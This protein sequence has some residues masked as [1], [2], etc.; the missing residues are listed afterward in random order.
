ML[1]IP[2]SWQA[3]A[4]KDA[5]VFETAKADNGENDV[6]ITPVE[7]ENINSQKVIDK[8]SNLQEIIQPDASFVGVNGTQVEAVILPSSVDEGN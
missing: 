4:V 2:F 7:N 3:L 8:N 6:P 1:A 5:K